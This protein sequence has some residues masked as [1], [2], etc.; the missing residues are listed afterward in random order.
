MY[1]NLYYQQIFPVFLLPRL[2]SGLIFLLTIYWVLEKS[3]LVID[4]NLIQNQHSDSSALLIPPQGGSSYIATTDDFT[5]VEIVLRK[6]ISTEH[7]LRRSPFCCFICSLLFIIY[8]RGF[9]PPYNHKG[10]QKFR[11]RGIRDS[12]DEPSHCVHEQRRS[13]SERLAFPSARR[14]PRH[15]G[16]LCSDCLCSQLSESVLHSESLLP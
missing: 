6:L 1:A 2:L 4:L 7:S 15:T 9:Y 8:S 12:M 10:C 13:Q 11:D 14:S 3:Q 5:S 16:F